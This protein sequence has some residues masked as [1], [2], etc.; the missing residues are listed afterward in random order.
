LSLG[1]FLFY[2][3]IPAQNGNE[4]QLGYELGNRTIFFFEVINYLFECLSQI[5][6][7]SEP[8]FTVQIGVD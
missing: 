2:R 7:G 3:T 6:F 1:D 4:F 5:V 8:L